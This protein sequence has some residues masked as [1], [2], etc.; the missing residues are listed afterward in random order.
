MDLGKK[1]PNGLIGT[2]VAEANEPKNI[3]E[4]P[5]ISIEKK[6]AGYGFGDTFEATV[7]FRVRKLSEGK[8]Y[9]SDEP[10][11]RMELEVMSMNITSKPKTKKKPADKGLPA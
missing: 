8:D 5:S 9:S 11:E 3:I 2:A 1:R 6:I 4:Y 10:T 7:K